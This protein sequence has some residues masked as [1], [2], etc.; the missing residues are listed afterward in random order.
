MPKSTKWRQEPIDDATLVYVEETGNDEE[1]KR[2][3]ASTKLLCY[4]NIAACQLKLNNPETAIEAANEA[5]KLDPR[6]V[7]ALYPSL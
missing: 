6:N 4:I 7:K 2:I 3:I 1:E 5:L